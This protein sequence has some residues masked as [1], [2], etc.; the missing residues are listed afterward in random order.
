MITLLSIFIFSFLVAFTGA[1]VPGP[2]LTYTIIRT[3][4]SK[5][6]GYLIGVFIVLGHALAELILII[7]LLFGFS[8]ILRFKYIVRII[9]IIGAL[10]LIYMGIE[11]IISIIRNKIRDVSID[12]NNTEKKSIIKNPSIGGIL[13]SMSNPYWWIWWGTIG[14]AFM[15]KY[16]ITIYNIPALLSFILGHELGDLL[17]YFTVSLLTFFGKYKL[18]QNIYN[19]IL[20]FCSIFI[21]GF[22]SYIGISIIFNY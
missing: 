12:N 2:L 19:L 9:G 16:N 18:N 8:S 21:V 6:N 4:Q 7:L 20:L 15:V 5:N 13:V 17:W 14:F 11:I 1:L 3:L 10:F 22:G